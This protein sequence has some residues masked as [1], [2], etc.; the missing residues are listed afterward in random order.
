MLPDSQGL[1]IIRILKHN[2]TKPEQTRRDRDGL[3]IF[4]N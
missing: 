2:L 4:E 1:A 3:F